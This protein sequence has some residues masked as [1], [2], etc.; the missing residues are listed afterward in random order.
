MTVVV[1]KEPG[2]EY[3]RRVITVGAPR[4][5]ETPEELLAA[6]GDYFDWV[7]NNPLKSWKVA[8]KDADLVETKH[9]RLPTLTG[10]RL[11]INISGDCWRKYAQRPEFAP[12]CSRVE[13]HIR[14]MK[15]EGASA[16]IFNPM[17]IARDLGLKDRSEVSDPT[18]ASALPSLDLTLLSDSEVDALEALLAKATPLT[19][20]SS[21]RLPSDPE[22]LALAPPSEPTDGER[23]A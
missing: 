10:M 1:H 19:V 16:E 11:H 4:K 8:G 18:G 23:A 2:D 3:W 13:E 6:C 15:L 12:T 17:I 5:F 22:P 20:V 21:E 14:Q 7:E 9:P